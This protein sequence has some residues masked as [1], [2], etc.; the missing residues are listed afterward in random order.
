MEKI[1]MEK[2]GGFGEAQMKQ[3]K[4]NRQIEAGLLD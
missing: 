4:Q 2:I 3:L 1:S